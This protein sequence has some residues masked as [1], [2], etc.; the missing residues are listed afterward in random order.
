MFLCKI[1]LLL[2]H[3][4]GLEVEERVIAGLAYPYLAKTRIV[5]ILVIQLVEA[6]V[7]VWRTALIAA[8]GNLLHGGQ[9]VGSFARFVFGGSF[10]LLGIHCGQ[11]LGHRTHQGCYIAAQK[12]CLEIYA[13]P[14]TIKKIPGQLEVFEIVMFD[15]INV[16][17]M[18]KLIFIQ[19]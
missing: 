19:I 16:L 12:S 15:F 14:G 3:L 9:A 11:I 17:I 2:L 1:N 8:I 5:P 4:Q 10:A 18:F 6:N 7:C 13:A